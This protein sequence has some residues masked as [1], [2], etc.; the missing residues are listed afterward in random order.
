MFW[1]LITQGLALHIH[2]HPDEFRDRFRVGQ[3]Q[4]EIH[5]RHHHLY[6][7]SPENPWEEVFADFCGNIASRI[8]EENNSQIV[9]SFSTTGRV[10]R[11][12]N[13][14]ALMDCVKSYFEFNLHTRCGI[15]QVVL[16]GCPADWE[17]LRD[18]TDSLGKTYGLSWWTERLLPIIDRVARNAGGKDDAE[19]WQVLYKQIDGSGGPYIGGWLADFFPYV[20]RDEPKRRNPAFAGGHRPVRWEEMPWNWCITTD[21]L[22]GPL[23][24][25][26]FRWFYEDKQF[27]MELLAGFIGFTQDADTLRLRP[28]IGWAVRDTNQGVPAGSKTV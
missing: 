18:K 25:V 15:P 24:R 1:L 10:E 8:G 6:K 5:V 27:S 28:K 26:P 20:G 2:Y 22:P 13:A 21:M 3:A 12:A 7:G 11:A 14:V 9:T 16:E 17:S 4:Q 23:S 19:L